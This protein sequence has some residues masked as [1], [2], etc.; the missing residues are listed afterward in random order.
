MCVHL[1]AQGR[2]SGDAEGTVPNAEDPIS[3]QQ[4]ARL[5]RQTM[6]DQPL[7]DSGQFN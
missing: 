7:T 3:G 2:E 4:L 5:R 6:A 1:R